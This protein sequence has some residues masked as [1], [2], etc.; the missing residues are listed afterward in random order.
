MLAAAARKMHRDGV[1]ISQSI[2]HSLQALYDAETRQRTQQAGQA[3]P[4][5]ESTESTAEEEAAARIR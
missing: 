1:S 5:A 3:S 2:N 4:P